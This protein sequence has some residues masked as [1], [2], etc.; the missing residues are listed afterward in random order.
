VAEHHTEPRRRRALHHRQRAQQAALLHDLELHEVDGLAPDDLDQRR[1]ARHALVGHQRDG[2]L[3][4]DAGQAGDVVARDRLL[5]EH[6]PVGLEAPDERRGVGGGQALVEVDAQGHPVADRGP[7]RGDAL[8]A[9][10]AGA[11]HL[12]LRGPEALREPGERLARRL[13]GRHR[14]D[15]GVQRDGVLHPPA[16][17]RVDG[18]AEDARLEIHQRHLDGGLCLGGAGELP[19][20]QRER[21]AHVERVGAGEGGRQT[22]DAVMDVRGGDGRVARRGVHV[23]PPLGSRIRG[24]M[25]QD[26]ALDR[27]DA[28]DAADGL[29]ERNVDEDRLDRLYSHDVASMALPPAR[30]K[31][32]RFRAAHRTHRGRRRRRPLTALRL[33][34]TIAGG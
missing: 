13:R 9:L 12:D 17:E 23:A 1:R 26:A 30:V 32:R 24:D 3:P 34:T 15:P 7:D 14:P 22:L 28:V 27:G 25:D 6:E 18:N 29:A 11:R 31:R 20:H 33:P 4:A 2:D 5:D 8:H 21:G 19:V 10:V 16:E